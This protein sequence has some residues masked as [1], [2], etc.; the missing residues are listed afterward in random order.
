[1]LSRRAMLTGGI[2]ALLPLSVLARPKAQAKPPNAQ[3]TCAKYNTPASIWHPTLFQGGYANGYVESYDLA[4]GALCAPPGAFTRTRQL[5][6]VG[7][8]TADN[9]CTGVEVSGTLLPP[10]PVNLV[11]PCGRLLTLRGA[12]PGGSGHP[13]DLW[14]LN[15]RFSLDDL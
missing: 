6:V 15:V 1:M 9:R 12:G 11:I 7:R 5:R 4:R 3:K 8:V 2:G 10:G 14:S 13:N